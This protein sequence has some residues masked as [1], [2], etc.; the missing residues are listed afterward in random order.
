MIITEGVTFCLVVVPS[1]RSSPRFNGPSVVTWESFVGGIRCGCSQD[2][3]SNFA[4]FSA[5][6]RQGTL[7]LTAVFQRMTGGWFVA[8]RLF[9]QLKHFFVRVRPGGA[10]GNHSNLHE[11][12][13]FGLRSIQSRIQIYL[14]MSEMIWQ[15]NTLRC[16]WTESGSVDFQLFSPSPKCAS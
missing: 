5:H 11:L 3:H 16:G 2:N 6:R 4:F 15:F 9:S 14:L 8:L 13:P 12:H 10:R 7:D 1:L